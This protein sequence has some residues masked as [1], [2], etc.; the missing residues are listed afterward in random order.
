MQQ[1]SEGLTAS[2]GRGW[3]T[4]QLRHCLRTAE[5]FPEEQIVSAVRRLLS[6]THIKTIMYVDDPLKS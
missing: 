3:S 5:T 1:L 4:K 6:W 2:H